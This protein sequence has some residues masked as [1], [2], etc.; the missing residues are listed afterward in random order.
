[1]ATGAEQRNGLGIRREKPWLLPYNR[2]L[3]NVISIS[4]RN[5][6]LSPSLSSRP[7]GK[8]IDDDALPT[9]LIS[10]AKLVALREKKSLGHS[11]SSSDLRRV[12]EHAI[13]VES[14]SEADGHA[15]GSPRKNDANGSPKTPSRPSLAKMRRRSTLEWANASPQKRQ[16]KLENVVADK[17]A[18]VF[19]SLHVPGVEEPIYIS[20]VVATTMNP[21]FRSFDLSLASPGTTRIE[22]FNLR[23]WVKSSK[24]QSW[25]QLVDFS[26]QL[27]V[28][29]YLGQH[30]EEAQRPLPPNAVLF[31]LRD[32]VYTLHSSLSD[33]APAA[34]IIPP[35]R[36]SN[37]G[38]T[39][40]TSSFDAL[41]KLGKLDDSIQDALEA[42]NRLAKDLEDL[43]NANRGALSERDQVTE[44]R[45]RLKTIEYAKKTVA[46]QMEKAQ[47]QKSEKTSTLANR[48]ELMATDLELRA[49]RRLEIRQSADSL[50]SEHAQQEQLRKNIESQRRRI[51]EDLQVAY[52]IRPIPGK[53][54]AFKIRDL[55]LPNSDIL[56]NESSDNVA[57]ALGHV[58][59]VLQLLSFYLAQPLLYPLTPR[60]STS[61]IYDPISLLK[62]STTSAARS[63]D[64][65]QA[66]LRTYPLFTRGTPRFRFE[67]AL[68]LLNKNIQVLL[69]TTFHVRVLDI[70]HTLPNLKYL[71]YVA[72]AG[73][74]ELPARKSGGVKGLLRV[75]ARGGLG[76]ERS[77]DST[78]SA[79]SGLL[80]HGGS[81]EGDGQVKGGKGAVESLKRLKGGLVRGGRT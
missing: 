79:L 38:R 49:K 26:V 46:K 64:K 8:T 5:L 32:G 35:I 72:T 17:M 66:L 15:N 76:R 63:N 43:I 75:S 52:P 80:W 16:E 30:A 48:R 77:D 31:Y 51:C 20:E 19:F 61:T 54:L 65:S 14:E 21:T 50:P 18:D 81:K 37:S 58:A 71:L 69:E 24:W 28:L 67:Y 70:R 6:S 11:R 39:M 3:R 74:G 22:R 40:G 10:P 9:T 13:S 62:P 68:F 2:K 45:D 59:A 27:S 7:R 29:Q 34:A 47:R 12:P 57:A 56:D 73:E 33:Y 41:L 60:G 4:L 53:T 1:M 36:R 44:A 78:S 42:R 25:R 23:L 55:Q